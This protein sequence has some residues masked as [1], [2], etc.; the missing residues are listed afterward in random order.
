MEKEKK[1]EALKHEEILTSIL[2]T[3]YYSTEKVEPTSDL[4]ETTMCK[5]RHW[6]TV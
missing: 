4:S 5:R 2:R 6:I 3:A 1:K